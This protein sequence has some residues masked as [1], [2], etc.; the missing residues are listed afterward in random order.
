[1]K[2]F[3]LLKAVGIISVSIFL[4]DFFY[5]FLP[6]M[7]KYVTAVVVIIS[8]VLDYY[9]MYFKHPTNVSKK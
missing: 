2:T 5:P 1:M 7:F 3:T 6:K 9:F 4:I 8:V